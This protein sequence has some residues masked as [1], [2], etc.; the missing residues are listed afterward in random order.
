MGERQADFKLAILLLLASA[1]L[2]AWGVSWPV[3]KLALHE[4]P[5]LWLVALRLGIGCIVLFIALGI[6]GREFLPSRQSLPLLLSVGL[7]QMGG[8]TML[9]TLGLTH[10]EAGR[11]AILAYTTP[12][13]VTPIAVLFFKEPLSKLALLGIILGIMGVVCLFNPLSFNWGNHTALM[14]NGLLLLAAFVWALVIIHIRFGKHHRTPLEL[15]PWQMLLGAIFI[16][17]MAYIFEPNPVIH[18]SWPLVAELSYLGPIA[19]AFAYWGAI[20]LNRQLPATTISLLLLAVPV[21]GLLSSA[22]ILGEKITMN[23]LLAMLL[24]LTGLAC[25]ALTKRKV[26]K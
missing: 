5:P 24:I 9:I 18:W 23:T 7:A 13:W 15:A 17:M 19:S 2:C 25:V 10:V 20:E 4:A 1:V 26:S 22:A 14:G 11:S 6:S 12:L 16:A 21:I 3:M 8:F